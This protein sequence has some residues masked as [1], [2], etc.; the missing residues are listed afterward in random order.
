MAKIGIYGGSF[1]PVHV[2]HLSLAS[3]AL[4]ELEL[5]KVIF[6]PSYIAPHK[7]GAKVTDNH[8]RLAMLKLA[9]QDYEGFEVS[10]L[11][12]KKADIS[13]TAN[14]LTLIH[15]KTPE[16]ELYFIMGGDSFAWLDGW[17]HSQVIFNLAHIVCAV[18]DDVDIDA[19]MDYKARYERVYRAKCHIL[20]M[21][22]VDV[23]STLIRDNVKSH[24][25]ISDLVPPA[26]EAYINTNRLYTGE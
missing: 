21:N 13:Y 22:N 4:E 1:D 6:M 5:D 2:G 11:E 20:R 12:I 7:T 23:S 3:A 10:D 18:R 26:V 14:T 15:E 17:Y 16:D 9:I 8:H 19:L 25:S 24:K